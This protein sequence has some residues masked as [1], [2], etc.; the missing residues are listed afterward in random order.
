MRTLK[1]TS[2][3]VKLA[4]KSIIASLLIISCSIFLVVI[5]SCKSWGDVTVLKQDSKLHLY[6]VDA[7]D[8]LSNHNN[9]SPIKKFPKLSVKEL[10]TLLKELRFSNFN[11]FSS[12]RS[13]VFY[14]KDLDYLVPRILQSIARIQDN[15]RM[16]VIYKTIPDGNLMYTSLRTTMVLW[17]DQEGFNLIIGEVRKPLLSEKFIS[18]YEDWHETDPIDVYGDNNEIN[19][20]LK[21]PFY[22]KQL[23]FLQHNTWAVITLADLQSLIESELKSNVEAEL[24]EKQTGEDFTKSDV[25]NK[26]NEEAIIKGPKQAKKIK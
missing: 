16:I 24:E 20:V 13:R 15:D 21:A 2:L 6:G 17:Y 18:H 19:L 25:D 3:A 4:A 10:R 8:Y 22:A 7:D 9:I 1:S 5:S 23:E 11:I 12:R 14:K 26:N